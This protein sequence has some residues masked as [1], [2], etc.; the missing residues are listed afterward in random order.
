MDKDLQ[1]QVLQSENNELRKKNENL[2]EALRKINEK[3]SHILLEYESI[4]K[5][6]YSTPF[7][8]NN[9]I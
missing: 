8:Y 4:K 5:R 1:I 2:L 9:Q 3:Y 7:F 6:S